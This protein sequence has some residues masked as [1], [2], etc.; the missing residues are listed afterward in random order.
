LRSFWPSIENGLQRYRLFESANQDVGT[1]AGSKRGT[2]GGACVMTSQCT[3]AKVCGRCEHLPQHDSRTEDT[4]YA[5]AG[6]HGLA[7][8]KGGFL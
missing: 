2:C 5:T 4:T 7:E 3:L 1:G 8:D 6:P